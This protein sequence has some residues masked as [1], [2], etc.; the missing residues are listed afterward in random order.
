MP[1]LM[2]APLAPNP[3]LLA[4]VL[5]VRSR[6]A[7][8]RL[9]FHYP[10]SASASLAEE[11]QF[12]QGNG[13]TR[14]AGE[15]K[16]WSSEERSD[17]EEE[18]GI[19]TTFRAREIISSLGDNSK[20]S[21]A[22][23]RGSW[24]GEEITARD[25]D[26]G[27][28]DVAETAS[29]RGGGTVGSKTSRLLNLGPG[30]LRSTRARAARVKDIEQEEVEVRGTGSKESRERA[31]N[32][33]GGI[34]RSNKA[35]IDPEKDR[36]QVLGYPTNELARLLCPGR[37]AYNKKRFEI[38][39]DEIAFL[40]AP[41]FVR[42]DGRWKKTKKRKKDS[43]RDGKACRD[44]S[45]A[46]GVSEDQNLDDD[47]N[48]ETGER[49]L[50][51][52]IQSRE[53]EYV[54]GFEP[55][56]GHGLIS[57]TPSAAPSEVG[58][59]DKS[60]TSNSGDEMTMF[61]LVFVL[62]PP[63]LEHQLRLEEMYDNVV[64]K[65]AKSLKYLQAQHNYVWAESQKILTMQEKGKENGTPIASL[66]P[67]IIGSSTLARAIATVF[68][69]ISS[70]KIA[71]VNLDKTLD[72]N[73]QIPHAISTPFVPTI[74][75]PQI[76]GLWLT[77]GSF[78][79]ADEADDILGPHSALLLLE[80]S[81]TLLKEI[82]GDVKELSESLSY[83]IRNLTPTKSLQKLA[84]MTQMSLKDMQVLGRHLIYWRK[85][86]AI[87]PLHPR[88]T[89]IVSPNANMK[90]LAND[91]PAYAA[92]FPTLPSLPKMLHQLSR[93]A[94]PKTYRHLMPSPD[95]RSAYMAILAWLMRNGYVTQL[96][97]F[98]WVRVPA[99]VKVAVHE[100]M[101]A[102]VAAKARQRE[103]GASD[104]LGPHTPYSP[105]RQVEAGG[106]VTSDAE[107]HDE[108]SSQNNTHESS[109][110]SRSSK[111]PTT[112]SPRLPPHNVQP[113]SRPTSATGS[114]SS[115]RT[116][117]PFASP[118]IKHTKASASG[119]KPS[120]LRLGETQR[121]RPLSPNSANGLLS[122]LSPSVSQTRN[123]AVATAP[124]PQPT[125]ATK[126]LPSL[127]H[128]PQK[129]NALESRWLE[130]IGSSFLDAELREVWPM[131][132]QY[133]DGQHALEEIAVRESQKRKRIAPVLAALREGGW[134]VVVRHW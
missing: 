71:L 26:E 93:D 68:E 66:W 41:M 75:E 87:P 64:K 111:S 98:A 89:Y 108:S 77:T 1:D 50:H 47:P 4:I 59:E 18:E 8:P 84:L 128:S 35:D 96:R 122:P 94:R 115:G 44:E 109:R 70:S 12:W 19:T 118:S 63:S 97:T 55:A 116:A 36:D 78:S 24:I 21:I 133:F 27:E 30:S 67:S 95:H 83:F 132:L 91:I 126:Q 54:E 32:I 86:R 29:S 7:Q 40:G 20:Q 14:T 5:T 16:S 10:L 131:L 49:A 88:D 134:L 82:E 69:A 102:E 31:M 73:F 65:F 125:P 127:I 123:A 38:G 72:V 28:D 103:E 129:A 39:L 100:E 101:N 58:S 56:Y 104:S 120:P 80:D 92:K 3:C 74:T 117:V 90:A 60:T 57:G 62:N 48:A 112:S 37:I 17:E 105:H 6:A 23:R 76:P 42:D 85:A 121:Q 130:H 110:S 45:E 79:D 25:D 107:S 51:S 22:A 11:S 46:N 106:V 34:G 61:N 2:A 124:H 119:R 53:L 52:L 9:V 43:K 13:S 114:T 81:E 99:E 113:S 15:E 33:S